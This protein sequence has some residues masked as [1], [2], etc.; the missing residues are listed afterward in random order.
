MITNPKLMQY[1]STPRGLKKHADF[2]SAAG[3]LK[4]KAESW[5]DLVWDNMWSKDGS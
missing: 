2:M 1:S 5:K 3:I 4:T